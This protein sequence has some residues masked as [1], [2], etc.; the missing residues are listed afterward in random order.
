MKK[1]ILLLIMLISVSAFS[2]DEGRRMGNR[3][4]RSPEEM[5]NFASDRMTKML[6]LNETQQEQVK[7]F[8]LERAEEMQKMRKENSGNLSREDRRKIMQ[9]A[10]LAED[11]EMQKILT[12]EQYQKWQKSREER[13]RNWQD[14][15]RRRN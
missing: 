11:E 5:A 12:E 14:G 15:N 3:A 13:R 10:A 7:S 4:N 6:D 2:Q 8:Y 9:E 1:L